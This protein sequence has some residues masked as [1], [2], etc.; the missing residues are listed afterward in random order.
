MAISRRDIER[1]LQTSYADGRY[2]RLEGALKGRERIAIYTLPHPLAAGSMLRIGPKN[3]RVEHNSHL[4]F[5]DLMHMANYAHPVLYELHDVDS[6]V[7]TT[8]E[9]QFP[10]ADRELEKSLIPLISPDA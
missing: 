10:L 6:G 4:V 8:I 5:I 3:Y 9:E 7:V 2:R 1:R